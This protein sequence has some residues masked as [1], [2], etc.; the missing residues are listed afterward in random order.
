MKAHHVETA[1]Q[2][3]SRRHLRD[4]TVGRCGVRVR[5]SMMEGEDKDE[6][7]S[8]GEVEDESEGKAEGEVGG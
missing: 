4:P 7:E 3:R 6:S 5:E 8:Q 1:G 2:A